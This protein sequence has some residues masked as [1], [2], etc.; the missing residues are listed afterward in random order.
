MP[1][2]RTYVLMSY[3]CHPVSTFS[4]SP[5]DISF[6][7]RL[8][9]RKGSRDLHSKISV[10]HKFLLYSPLPPIRALKDILV[11][12]RSILCKFFETKKM[13]KDSWIIEKYSVILV[14]N[15]TDL[16]CFV[17]IDKIFKE[18]LYIRTFEIRWLHRSIMFY[19]NYNNL[20]PFVSIF[21][22]WF[23]GAYL[24]LSSWLVKTNVH[25]SSSWVNF[26]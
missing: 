20:L 14:L 11:T 10:A 4:N 5:S 26:F 12:K 18:N 24:S 23:N 16:I 21:C 2:K 1:P 3:K 8:H 6:E 17:I 7:L 9:S 19:N 13:K 22:G 25:Y 15:F